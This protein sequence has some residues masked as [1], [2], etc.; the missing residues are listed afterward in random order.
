[1]KKTVARNSQICNVCNMDIKSTETYWAEPY[2]SYC[3]ECGIKKKE[4]KIRWDNKAKTYIDVDTKSI[5]DYCDSP[6][7]WTG[8]GH[9]VCD[10]HLGNAYDSR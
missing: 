6:T 8:K 2:A 4:N 1:M 7:V 10:D 3:W 5:C 9:A